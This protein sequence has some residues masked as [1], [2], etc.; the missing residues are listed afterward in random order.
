MNNIFLLYI[1]IIFTGKEH[2]LVIAN[3]KSDIDWLIGWV[4]AQVI[5]Y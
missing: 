2:A 4:F 5:H 3:H 1:R